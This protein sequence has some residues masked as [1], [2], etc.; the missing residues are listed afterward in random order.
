MN[1]HLLD[2]SH[3]CLGKN[4]NWGAGGDINA[5]G[6]TGKTPI[7]LAAEHGYEDIAEFLIQRGINLCT[8][9]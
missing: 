5:Q 2:N 3:L 9:Q 8:A 6:Y 1:T 7:W 4:S